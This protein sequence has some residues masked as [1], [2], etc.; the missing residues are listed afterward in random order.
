MR[1]QTLTGPVRRLRRTARAIK[2]Q[3]RSQAGKLGAIVRNVRQANA[4]LQQETDRLREQANR[5]R[6]TL[7]LIQRMRL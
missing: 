6:Q 3:R 2:R 1:R 7:E 5:D 4:E